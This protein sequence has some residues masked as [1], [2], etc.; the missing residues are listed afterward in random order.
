M[1]DVR[2]TIPEDLIK[3]FNDKIVGPDGNIK[4]TDIARD[5]LSLYKWAIDEAS[6][7]RAIVSSDQQGE[8]VQRLV[9]PRLQDAE[10][11]AA[12]IANKK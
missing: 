3:E 9:M 4:T 11:Q 6:K 2:L 8:N 12:L 5:A 7:G 10:R 1:A